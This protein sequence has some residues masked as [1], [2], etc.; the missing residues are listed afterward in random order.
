MHIA[1]L[2]SRNYLISNEGDSEFDNPDVVHCINRYRIN[3]GIYDL[4][5]ETKEDE[6]LSKILQYCYEGWPKISGLENNVKLY[7]SMKNEIMVNDDV[8]HYQHKIIIPRK[9]LILKLL[10]ESHLG[11]TK[12][13]IRA[14]YIFFWHGMLNEIYYIFM[15][16][17]R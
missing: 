7:F 4:P 12:I 16:P 10:H 14:K 2:L 1:D 17:H 3:N 11:I 6:V 5:K 9:L 15:R 8:L 13:K